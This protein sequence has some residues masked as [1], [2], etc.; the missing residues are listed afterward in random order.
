MLYVVVKVILFLEPLSLLVSK[1]RVRALEMSPV[2][3]SEVNCTRTQS[4]THAMNLS[5]LLG[6]MS[7]RKRLLV[8]WPF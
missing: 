3:N 5:F 8:N 6:Q 7:K 1:R 2:L 4:H